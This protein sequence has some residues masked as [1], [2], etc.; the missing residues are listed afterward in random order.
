MAIFVEK[1][2]IQLNIKASELLA[3]HNKSDHASVVCNEPYGQVY[4]IT[5]V[6]SLGV[7]ASRKG[8]SKK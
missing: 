8:S 6:N 1:A 4:L 2:V 7:N 3:C 5:E